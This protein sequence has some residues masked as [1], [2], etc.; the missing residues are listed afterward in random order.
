MNVVER[1]LARMIQGHKRD[2]CPHPGPWLET[3]EGIPWCVACG[4]EVDGL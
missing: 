3:E 2:F 4:R 1:A